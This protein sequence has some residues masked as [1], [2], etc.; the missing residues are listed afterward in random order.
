[1]NES[2]D[3]RIG[4]ADRETALNALGEHLSAGRLDVD[5]YGERSARVTA[6]KTRRELTEIFTDLP[7]PRPGVAPAAAAVEKPRPKPGEP[8]AWS[9]RPVG[10]RVT[11]GILPLLFV[12]A[13][14]V[15]LTTGIWWFIAVPFIVGAVGRG[16][17]GP[18]WDK[19]RRDQRHRHP[20]RELRDR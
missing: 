20:R 3:V 17:W 18:D 8:I 4:D 12:G 19:D 13:I 10:Q 2:P 15:G 7:A 14:V 11:A 9:D 1:M 5:E 16:F 6:A